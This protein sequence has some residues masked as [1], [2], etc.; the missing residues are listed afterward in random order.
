MRRLS[1]ARAATEFICEMPTLI[2]N[3]RKMGLKAFYTSLEALPELN[4][5]Y[6]KLLSWPPSTPHMA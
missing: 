5:L 1:A 3:V 4:D 6:G 2:H